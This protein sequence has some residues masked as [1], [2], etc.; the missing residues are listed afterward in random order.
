MAPFGVYHLYIGSGA[1]I[2]HDQRS[3]IL[4]ICSDRSD[5]TVGAHIPRIVVAVHNVKGEVV[6]HDQRYLIIKV[7]FDCVG[8]RVHH[9]GHDR[10]DHNVA[11]VPAVEAVLLKELAG[12]QPNLIRSDVAVGDQAERSNDLIP[13]EDSKFHIGVADVDCEQ[14]SATSIRI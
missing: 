11:D 2:D 10:S 5:Q 1:E 12:K 6:P 4:F 7:F 14:H 13:T 3:A 8:D 9:L